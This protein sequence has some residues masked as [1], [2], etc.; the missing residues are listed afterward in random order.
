LRGYILPSEVEFSDKELAKDADIGP[1]THGVYVYRENRLIEMATYFGLFRRETHLT[2]LR[3][4]F[5]YDGA[6]DE[7]FHTA[8]KKGSMSLGDLEEEVHEFLRPL[9]REA[10]QRSRGR[11]NKVDTKGIHDTSQKRIS[12]AEGRVHHA[13]IEPLDEKNAMVKSKYGQVVLP[14]P[15]THDEF[16]ALPINPVE[17]LLDGQLWQLRLHNGRQVV[18]IS[19]NHDFYPKVYLPNRGNAVAVQGLDMIFWALAITEAN[20]AIPE[21]Q[22]QFREFRYEVSKI[23]RELVETLP[24]VRLD[25]EDS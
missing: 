21:Y 10:N 12:A 24:E 9:V 25:E 16:D 23:L 3:V 7:L 17:S 13:S 2:G 18:E 19:K 15:S 5:S 4:E 8:I 11:S 20:C 6:L 1:S 14:I 22:K